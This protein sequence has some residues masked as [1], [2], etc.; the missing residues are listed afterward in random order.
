MPAGVAICPVRK[1]GALK[2]CS[3]LVALLVSVPMK[4]ARSLLFNRVTRLASGIL[5]IGMTHTLPSANRKSRVV[6]ETFAELLL[7]AL[8]KSPSNRIGRIQAMGDVEIAP[9][10]RMHNQSLH[11]Q[12]RWGCIRVLR[13]EL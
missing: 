9:T 11:H 2:F 12:I 1:Y 10:L 8:C 4:K 6:K 5:E 7:V 3:G 13:E